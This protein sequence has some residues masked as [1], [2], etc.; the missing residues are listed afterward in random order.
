MYQPFYIEAFK[1][2]LEKDK[3]D[4]KLFNDAFSNI[5][6]AFIWRDRISRK[7]G[8]E[9]IGRLTRLL[10]AQALGNTTGSPHAGNIK[11]TLT[12]E[13]NAELEQSSIS[14]A[15]AA[16]GAETFTEPATPDGT[17]VGTGGGTGTINYATGAFTITSGAGW[18]A[19][20]AITAAFNYYPALPCMG[21]GERLL[22]TINAEQ[23]VA[24]DTSYVYF[25][26]GV[27]RRFA[28]SGGGVTWQGSNSQFFWTQ[29]YYSGTANGDIFFATNFNKS[30]TPDPIRYYATTGAVWTNFLPSIDGAG[31]ELHQ[32]RIII[33]YK[34]RIVALN[35][36]E[37]AT[38][39][40]ST[41]YP[42]RARWSQN[43]DALAVNAWRDDIAGRGSYVD[44]PTGEHII[45]AM[46]I[47]DTLIVG[48]EK[49][50]WRLRYT[51]NEIL[52]F[53][54]EQVDNEFG[55]ESTFSVIRA[56]RTQVSVGA[57][58]IVACN[59]LNSQR[60]DEKI[61]DDV[62]RIH[63]ENEGAERVH[64]IRDYDKQL[65]YWT[66]PISASNLTYPDRVL[67]YNYE[68]GAWSYFHDSFTCFGVLQEL[69]D[70][71]WID[72][73]TTSWSEANFSWV[74]NSIQSLY[75]DIIAGTPH[76][77]VVKPQKFT[78][79]EP[80]FAITVITPGTPVR[81]T[82]PDH[83]L[84]NGDFVKITGIL[85]TSNVL[86]D[87]IY[88][89]QAITT[90]TID[91]SYED[92]TPVTV[93]AGSTYLG[94]GEIAWMHDYILRTKKFNLLEHGNSFELGIIDF[95][96]AKTDYGEFNVNI[97]LDHNES[98][99]MNVGDEFF[100][101]TMATYP[102]DTDLLNQDTLV[103][104]MYSREV[105][106]FVQLE[107]NLT[108]EQK[109]NDNIH[110]SDIEIYGMTLWYNQAGRIVR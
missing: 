47:G 50:I 69:A 43:G 104:R 19:G 90:D 109:A 86:N 37:G 44:A 14:I 105:G 40:A 49:S 16:P 57:R 108:P 81:L 91:L 55:V 6:D 82:V 87:D 25:W 26:D 36:W 77:F 72:F 98:E 59:G 78:N 94:G 97:F 24:F 4:F 8:C 92:G 48:F 74:S 35:T 61:P 79:N 95:I 101:T 76:G 52:P 65:F 46:F 106:Q 83:N 38:L 31:N 58:G 102:Y 15:V 51:S 27:N 73:P 10:T 63:N 100:N 34:G 3:S 96:V 22:S 45:S 28:E 5:L 33:P 41:Q 85:G 29:N 80:Y 42:R 56:D 23:S 93:A 9:Q 32:C 12:L 2:G 11:T 70:R 21:F 60:I 13:A 75:P 107:L 17:L 54:W 84:I 103:H 88:M 89:V 71:R 39:A 68:D 1:T 53:V 30:G 64:G 20:Q 7:K 18:G 99:P 62:F 66:Y 67:V 110:N